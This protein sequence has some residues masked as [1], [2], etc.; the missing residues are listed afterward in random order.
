[1]KEPST[2]VVPAERPER[3]AK[4]RAGR[5]EDR[6][7]I[8]LLQAADVCFCRIYHSTTVR[9]PHRLP[10]TGAGILVCN[11]ISGLDP[12][13]LQSVLPRVIVWMMAKEYY[14][15]RAI[16]RIFQT[17]EA[18]PVDRGGRDLASTRAALRALADGRILGIFPEGRISKT[19]EFLPFQTGVAMIAIK[20]GVP[21]Y[22]AF[23]DGT[24][25]GKTMLDAFRYRN[26]TTITFGPP[27]EFDRSGT[28]KEILQ[29]GADK[30]MEAVEALKVKSRRSA[31]ARG[32]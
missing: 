5:P 7:V 20:T 15:M 13:L 18:I 1:V 24:M 3:P 16:K 6:F 19:D 31:A 11:H 22:P 9:A 23:I 10:R 32:A 27:V 17:I 12:F 30:M 25:R 4:A 2:S 26:R 14:E 21:V 28:S 29:A 8:R